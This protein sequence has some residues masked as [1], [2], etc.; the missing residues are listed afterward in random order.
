VRF[1]SLASLIIFGFLTLTACNT[2]HIDAENA[3]DTGD[4]EKAAELYSQLVDLDSE[5]KVAKSELINARNKIV[6]KR[7][8]EI[9]KARKKGNLKWVGTAIIKLKKQVD[10]WD[11]K[12]TKNHK[13]WLKKET[14]YIEKDLKSTV[15][16]HLKKAHPA[17]A[18]M[19]IDNHAFFKEYPTT[20]YK[21]LSKFVK[22]KGRKHCKKL[23][24]AKELTYPNFNRLVHQYCRFW[25]VALRDVASQDID[26][27]SHQYKNV[28]VIGRVKGL[29]SNANRVLQKRLT[30][31]LIATPWFTD[32]GKNVL[33]VRL[34][35]EFL[36][37]KT[38]NN[39]TR[40]HT[41]NSKEAKTGREITRQRNY[42][43]KMESQSLSIN[44]KADYTIGSKR[45]V[46]Q[47]KNSVNEQGVSHNNNK[48]DIGLLPEKANLT[49]SSKWL[50]AHM[51]ALLD[52]MFVDSKQAWEETYC[53]NQSLNNKV[54][55]T[56]EAVE[57]CMRFS[58]KTYDFVDLW[59]EKEFG[60]DYAA[61]NDN[62]R[63]PKSTK[64][65]PVGNPKKT[66][67]EAKIEA[68]ESDDDF[69][70]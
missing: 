29:G 62:V 60:L 42:R 21:K 55:K 43:A 16:A 11:H 37:T 8:T 25:G 61:Y 39:I 13:L 44:L 63:D 69:D 2:T 4:Y 5:D 24:L 49:N 27:Q 28:A 56:G 7:L 58:N 1:L 15:F 50:G 30:E 23:Y 22:K 48:P 41:Y 64:D 31:K 26:T 20:Y 17:P 67:G 10:E 46:A 35:G 47:V 59:F 51:T 6:S 53:Q 57:R 32:E 66:E 36:K 54:A 14:G 9:R 33:T 68:E 19:A 12:L 34:S 38:K 3:M 18:K 65:I 45:F 70:I 40:V 52:R